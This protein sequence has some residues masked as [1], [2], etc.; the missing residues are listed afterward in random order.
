MNIDKEQL[1]GRYAEMDTGE[2]LD[3]LHIL[4]SRLYQYGAARIM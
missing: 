3:L 1:S 2:L 4:C